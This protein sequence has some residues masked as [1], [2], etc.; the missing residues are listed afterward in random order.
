MGQNNTKLTKIH[1]DVK[2][3][4]LQKA[5]E[6]NG[7]FSTAVG[8]LS[9]AILHSI[10][11]NFP[12]NID[13]KTESEKAIIRQHYK[14]FLKEFAHVYPCGNCRPHFLKHVSNI[15]DTAVE[16]RTKFFQ[17]LYHLHNTVTDEVAGRCKKK[18]KTQTLT[19]A[20]AFAL[21]ESLRCLPSKVQRG[22]KVYCVIRFQSQPPKTG[23]SIEIEK[24]I[25]LSSS[26]DIEQHIL[27]GGWVPESL[28]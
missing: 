9:W 6:T 23:H 2:L 21:F 19:E 14:N 1:K 16:N 25:A 7:F 20:Q 22:E 13:N 11:L 4:E 27:N 10:A 15:P 12:Y 17:Y 24:S 5:A 18:I 28:H 8:P 26:E 3:Q